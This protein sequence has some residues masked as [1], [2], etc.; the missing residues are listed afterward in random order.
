MTR[1]YSLLI[2]PRFLPKK[3]SLSAKM[4][5]RTCP[6]VMTFSLRLQPAAITGSCT[7]LPSMSRPDYSSSVDFFDSSSF[8]CLV[9]SG[10]GCAF[11]EGDMMAMPPSA[12]FQA[13]EGS[14]EKHSPSGGLLSGYQWN[15]QLLQLELDEMNLSQLRQGG[16]ASNAQS[17]PDTLY[18]EEAGNEEEDR[19][20][21]SREAIERDSL[22][23]F[24]KD[25]GRDQEQAS[26]GS[27]QHGETTRQQAQSD[28][29]G[30]RSAAHTDPSTAAKT[31]AGRERARRERL[32]E[33]C[34]HHEPTLPGYHFP[35]RLDA[36]PESVTNMTQLR[37]AQARSRAPV[38][39][40]VPVGT[41]YTAI[42]TCTKVLKLGCL[43]AGPS[44][45]ALRSSL[46]CSNLAKRQ[47]QTS[48]PSS[49]MPSESLHNYVQRMGSC[50]NSTNF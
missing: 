39:E 29:K 12:F 8:A 46:K 7:P 25:L 21:R 27:G 23:H 5:R 33:R 15:D 17:V 4:A 43:Q 49:L 37:D 30:K 2:S 9:F 28:E 44:S 11:N 3:G 42:M 50:G 6:H 45:A 40:R 10:P 22:E 36:G 1:S 47:K 31:K 35:P 34:A 13:G 20:K 26:G 19:R 18:L 48:L 32:N 38:S 14:G 24:L 16:P 41:M